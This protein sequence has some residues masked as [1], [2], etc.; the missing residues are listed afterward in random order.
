MSDSNMA[1]SP[2]VGSEGDTVPRAWS[3]RAR[4]SNLSQSQRMIWTG[5]RLA[6]GAPLYNMG[7]RFD[8]TG[9]LDPTTFQQ[10][11]QTLVDRT[12]ALRIV[13][14]EEE[15]VPTQRVLETL[16]FELE[17]VDL[18]AETDSEHV[19][20]RWIDARIGRT[21][22][23][24]SWTFDTALLK[25]G[26]D[27]FTWYLCQHHLTTDAWSSALLFERL[28]DLYGVLES[29]TEMP[30]SPRFPPYTDY[31]AYERDLHGSS[32]R[33]AALEHW[34]VLAND[35]PPPI[36]PY[37]QKSQSR[38]GRFERVF[39]TLGPRRSLQLRELAEA[40]GV[41]TLSRHL[42][43]FN[44]FASALAAYL[45]RVGGRRD[46]LIGTPAHNRSSRS[47]RETA[48]LFVEMFPLR[49]EVEE[50]DSFDDLLGR[51]S[52]STQQ[53]I[54]H[55]L[56]GTSSPSTLR[57]F[58]VVLNY[59]HA[60]FGDFARKPTRP[61]WL[62][63]GHG[64]P[65]LD[66]SLH[67][68]DVE[69]DGSV[70]LAFDFATDTFPPALR[71]SAVE[72][73]LALLDAMLG[74]RNA[75]PGTVALTTEDERRRLLVEFNSTSARS[76]PSPSVVESF[77]RTVARDPAA[78]ALEQG[79][80]SMSYGELDERSDRL[81]VRL[82]E[83]GAGPG[84]LVGIHAERSVEMV[85]GIMAVLK[86]GAAYVPLERSIPDRR[87]AHILAD[88]HVELVLS[89]S[90][91][92][93]RFSAYD[94]EVVDLDRIP[95]GVAPRDGSDPVREDTAYVIYTSGS[96]GTPKGV[97]VDHGGL[98]DYVSWA[99]STYA[100]GEAVDMPLHS[101]FGFDLTVTSIFLPLTCGGRVVVYVEEDLDRDLAVLDVF[102]EDRVDVVKLTPAH[103]R[104]VVESGFSPTRIRTLVLGG[105]NLESSLAGQAIEQW[106]GE[107][108]IF[109]E[110][111]PTEAVVGCMVH[112]FDPA[113]DKATSVPIGKPADGV[114]IYI[115]DAGQNPVPVGVAG[116]LC[117]GGARLAKG[118]LN[119]EAET[120]ARFVV[121][122]F[123]D[124]GRMYRTGDRARFDQ[125]GRLEYLGRVDDQIQIGGVRVEPAEV[126]QALLEHPAVRQC[127]CLAT[128]ATG[129]GA[130]ATLT[131]YVVSDV[132]SK[133]D[134]L[135]V[136]LSKRVPGVM[137]PAAFVHLEAIPLTPN[138]KIDR[139]A[140][141]APGAEDP[142]GATPYRSPGTPTEVALARI[143]SDVLGGIR[144][145]LDDDFFELGGDSISAIRVAARAAKAGMT[146]DPQDLFRHPTVSALAA[147]ASSAAARGDSRP[148][149]EPGSEVD[150]E[151]LE[152]LAKVLKGAG[153]S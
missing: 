86:S 41:R 126:E 136:F 3:S 36:K 130:S 114:Q 98:A 149:R 53:L 48:G 23:L 109:N 51:V 54:R 64:D 39:C 104:L 22:D 20:E 10:A 34:S 79:A 70:V 24:A 113:V 18:T 12:D 80:R 152:K 132:Q 17:F 111:G 146:L 69:G 125:R 141:P 58:N 119:L 123:V 60:S 57:L 40:P 75:L 9:A 30:G 27:R 25:T 145:G 117:I 49:V 87:L 44:I 128:D 2:T 46:V 50:S 21:L 112:C 118:Y 94:V 95:R 108:G 55:A 38:T 63:S 73:F 56:P 7:Y 133:P 99:G 32:A 144:V 129:S 91:L 8:V 72:H 29:G 115:L 35:A 127:V 61:Q 107:V 52:V 101:A 59:I 19:L 88:T 134:E 124:G 28:S 92:A 121:D 90:H 84:G 5:Q 96:T 71:A 139:A 122:P 97:V 148:K 82:R 45:W 138:G 142:P 66:L 150:S 67:V 110:Y 43:S 11:F 26:P 65:G 31:L 103:L 47:F 83:L 89:R 105:E 13:F 135:R 42:S 137:I 143:W 81:A 116:E 106:P 15:G 151:Q 33:E 4:V 76:A 140:L 100:R 6:P 16:P 1:H 68:L 147:R 120:A 78:V 102:A 37:G 85:V 131:A 74:D 77:R 153:P 14:D 93:D 62:H